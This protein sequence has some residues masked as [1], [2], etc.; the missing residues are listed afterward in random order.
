MKLNKWIAEVVFF[1]L[2]TNFIYAQ[3]GGNE[4]TFFFPVRPGEINYLSGTMGEIRS[5]HFHAGIDIKTSGISGL[6][7]YATGDGF[8]SRINISS[9]GY[10][11]ALYIKHPNGMTSVYG[12][13]LQFRK[14][15]DDYVREE[16]Y[17]NET[18]NIN[19]FPESNQFIIERGDLIGLSGNTGSS[20]GPHLH[21]EIRDKFQRPVNPLKIGFNEIKDNIPPTVL[22]FA[23]ISKN[24]E[25]RINH[26]FGRF[27]F[28]VKRRGSE[29]YIDDPIEVYGEFGVQIL[30]HDKLNGAANRNGIPDI[31]MYFDATEVIEIKIDTF[32][33]GDSRHVLN[34]YD[35]ETRINNRK[36][37]QKLY[38][39]DGNELPFYKFE[40]NSGIISVRDYKI[41]E[42]E[43]ELSDARGNVSSLVI[44]VKGA[45]ANP[46]VAIATIP[47]NM[48]IT[49]KLI[50]NNLLISVPSQ[51]ETPAN[52]FL[53]AN[54]MKYELLPAYYS[55]ERIFFLWD[56]RIGLPDSINS[57]GLSNTFDY[58]VMLPS[59]TEFNFYNRI[60][61]I[62]SFR[63][64]LYDTV[65]L[66]ADYMVL[67]DHK[68]EIFSIGNQNT[69]LAYPIQI[70][71][72]P[73]L[74]YEPLDKYAVY[75]STDM[76]NF[77]FEGNEWEN[78]Q[79]K[80]TTRTFG[81]FT[82]LPDTIGP[83]ITPVQLNRKRASF[84]IKD[85][86]AG[87][88]E[89]KATINGKWLLMHYDPKQDLIWSVP[90]IPNNP[91]N[92]EFILYVEDQVG[93]INQFK[94]Q[95]N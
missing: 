82:I 40:K 27:E 6:P 51:S 12:H 9:G 58:E 33:F 3:N 11:H 81:K 67:E 30:A 75:S 70:N 36:S 49:T 53:F 92:G 14:D 29:F 2:L 4:R 47:P 15:I 77:T 61:D 10:G 76:N 24:S 7:V 19:L 79:I 66:E 35:F 68:L 26:L 8:I 42:I 62:K 83:V 69:P 86:L 18:F 60:F 89:F 78:G 41:H 28:P 32:S 80:I 55:S 21:F 25:S 56:M 90:L 17:R 74:L 16:Q 91:I 20:L 52:A 5:T 45:K 38:I 54:R 37:F 87:I 88:K 23:L 31:T 34:F 46:E 39:D 94:T 95:I 84:K 64:S 48:D 50:E 13:L 57:C 44:P 85:D 22:S 93:N 71:F 63:R 1:I 73:K 59:A 65:Y 72:K 43:I